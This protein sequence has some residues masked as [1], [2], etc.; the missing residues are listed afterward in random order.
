MHERTLENVF[1]QQ[2]VHVEGQTDILTI[3]LPY[4]CP[5]NVNSIMNPILVMC[6]GL[7]Y[8][9]NLYRGRP[10]VRR[11]RRADHD[12][13]D[14]VGVQ[15]GPPPE[16]HRLLRAGAGRDHR[17]GRDRA[18][19]R[20]GLRRGRVVPAPL[21]DQLRLPR[22]P[23]V[24]HVVLGRPR[25]RASGRHHHVIVVGGDP[26]AVRRLG[27]RP[28]STMDDALEMASDIVG[29]DATIT[30]LHVPPICSWPRCR[31]ED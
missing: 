29:R 18:A 22:R 10:L 19:V 8:F 14:A 5:Y 25:P 27:F 4:I 21:P 2:L 6:L 26:R 31:D 28:A 24:L 13:P 15:P 9:F 30:H 17:P 16:L 11:G 23:P 12:P 1:R 3:G 20:E 7:G